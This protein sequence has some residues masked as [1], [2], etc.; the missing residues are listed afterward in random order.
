MNLPHSGGRFCAACNWRLYWGLLWLALG[1]GWA[2]THDWLLFAFA[3]SPG[4]T[5]ILWHA[6]HCK[7]ADTI[8]RARI[9]IEADDEHIVKL[10]R[11]NAAAEKLIRELSARGGL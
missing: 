11:V 8:D 9:V 1:G 3:T 7:Q 6:D 4:L 10:Q 2:L 5:F